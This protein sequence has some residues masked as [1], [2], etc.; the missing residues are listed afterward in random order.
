MKK[1]DIDHP[2]LYLIIFKIIIKVELS[3]YS[4]KI[5]NSRKSYRSKDSFVSTDKLRTKIQ[6]KTFE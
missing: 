1:K 5:D 3:Y 2:K 6:I 4:N